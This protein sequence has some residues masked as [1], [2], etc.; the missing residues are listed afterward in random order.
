MVDLLLSSFLVYQYWLLFGV[1]I[2]AAFGFPLP[3]TALLLAGGA[4]YA[5]GY[6]DI[7]YLFLAGFSG[8]VIGDNL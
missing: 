2:F 3:A 5:Q 4:L 6:F 7:I 8:C 1:C